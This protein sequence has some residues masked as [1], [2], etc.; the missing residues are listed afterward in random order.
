MAKKIY[1]G[2]C[3]ALGSVMRT[4]VSTYTK[5]LFKLLSTQGTNRSATTARPNAQVIIPY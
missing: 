3:D 5:S 4:D 2:V 1:A